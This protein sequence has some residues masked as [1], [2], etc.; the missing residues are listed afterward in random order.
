MQY[1]DRAKGIRLRL[2]DGAIVPLG[3]TYM[4]TGRTLF[5]KG[6]HDEALAEYKKAQNIFVAK[7]G[8]NAHF[9]AQCVSP[10][11][12]RFVSTNL[13]QLSLNYAYGNLELSRQNNAAAQ[14]YYG[15]AKDILEK[16]TPLHLLMAACY[17][18]LAH[19]SE[20]EGKRD[21]A[22]YDLSPFITD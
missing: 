10:L 18:K 4:T 1:F 16:D 2:G 7:F 15:R 9:M 12:F 5:L 8:Q 19:L 3:V 17:Y 22:L 11:S 14:K 21:E 13:I 6:K 20:I